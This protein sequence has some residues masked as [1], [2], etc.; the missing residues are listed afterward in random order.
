MASQYAK[1]QPQGTSNYIDNIAIVGAGGRSGKYMVEH[2]MKNGKHNITALTREGS[3]NSM[4]YGVVVKKID[5]SNPDTIVSALQGQD[6]FIITVPSGSSRD[7]EATLIKA[8]ADA[9]VPWVIPNDYF[10][11]ITEQVGKDLL[12]GPMLLKTREQIQSLGVSSWIAIACGFWYEFSLGGGTARYGFDIPRR[13]VLWFDDG[14]QKIN[15]ATFPQIGRA[16]ANLLALKVLPHDEND[17]SLC[18]DH[19]RNSHVLVSSF[20]V[21]QRD[22]FESLLRATGTAET[23]WKMDS[24]PV[25]QIYEEAL[26]K[27]QAGDRTSLSAV[28]VLYSRIFFPDDHPGL[29]EATKPLDNDRVGLPEEDIDEFTKIAVQLAES[30]SLYRSHAQ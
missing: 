9:K 20:T 16:V 1:D 7:L 22:M 10:Y 30:K 2:L 19:F 8:A 23:D 28:Q 29:M 14:R 17:K 5:Y 13:E 25:K 11:P 12:L 15:T 21:S 24:K 27:L 6:C 4:P 26:A 3:T 18:L